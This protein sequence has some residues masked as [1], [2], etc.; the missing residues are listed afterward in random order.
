[1][2]IASLPCGLSLLALGAVFHACAGGTVGTDPAPPPEPTAV[3]AS[4]APAVSITPT[5]PDDLSSRDATLTELAQF[6]WQE[7]LAL[8]W[9]SAIDPG[10]SPVGQRGVPDLSW[11][12]S[13]PGAHPTLLVWQTYAQTTE[14]R[15]NGPLTV[16]FDQLGTPRYSYSGT[17]SSGSGSPS[18]TLWNNLDEDN[19]IGSCD[20]YGQYASQQP[21]RNLV[22][23]QVKVNSDEYEYLRTNFG[24]DQDKC[25]AS[26]SMCPEANRTPTG[27]RLYQAQQQV[28]ANIKTLPYEY[29]PG[30]PSTADAT[31]DCPPEKAICL[32]CGGAPN[33]AGGTYE[34]AIE[35]KS[36]WRMLEP[37]DDP[38]RFY[39]TEAIYYED[40]GANALTYHNGTF[41]LIG[42]HI[43]HKTRNFPD[44]VFATFEQVDVETANMVYATLDGTTEQLPVVPIVRQ[45]GQTNPLQNH[46]VPP[47]LD[48]VTAAVHQQLTALNPE[49]IWQYYRL[50][51]VSGASVDCAPSPDTGLS[52]PTS[53][54]VANQTAATCIDLDPNYYMAN[55]VI[56]S[57]PFLNNFSGPGF[58]TNPFGNCRNTVYANGIYDNGGCKGCHGV[59]QT[60]FGT[61]FSF[62]LDFG[63][64]KPSILPASINNPT[65][66]PSGVAPAVAHPP[67]EKHYVD[68]L[69]VATL[70][71]VRR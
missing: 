22:L 34:G 60:S 69:D 18:F 3:T 23:Y 26:D 62:L 44:F 13:T 64:N 65:N 67:A 58:G 38:S 12:Y 46:P 25:A 7:F 8:S 19:E 41:A 14:L 52:D 45:S 43:I 1:M 57:D 59:A 24:A 6:A 37:G 49:T 50:T 47:T 54:C 27:G 56:E 17:V 48:T 35:V 10:E 31:C 42:L 68:G 55:F 5:P 63:N 4:A 28:I 33:P 70:Q 16:P 32:P 66:D 30:Q 2:K 53:D 20:V 39:T 9:K 21:P 15:P 36:A 29:Y 40:A 71:G 61:D 11:S 51:G